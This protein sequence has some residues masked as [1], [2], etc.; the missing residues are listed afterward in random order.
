MKTLV[1]IG[2]SWFLAGILFWL[3]FFILAPA[4][5]KAIPPSEW[6]PLL[7]FVVYGVIAYFGGIGVP[8]IIGIFGSVFVIQITQ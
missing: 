4:V 8:L 7:D 6:K 1:G 3:C 2:I 5:A